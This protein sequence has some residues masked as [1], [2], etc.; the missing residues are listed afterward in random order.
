MTMTTY[1]INTATLPTKYGNI[2]TSS[3]TFTSIPIAT[4]STYGSTYG[5]LSLG[6]T[7][8]A[9]DLKITGD[10]NIAG[11]SLKS[12]MQE[13]SEKL[14]V[15]IPNP[16]LEKDWEELRDLANK[17]RETESRIKSQLEVW[18]ALKHGPDET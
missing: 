2:S 17:Y 7:Y 5:S 4:T 13:V 6:H 1:T 14:G 8:P 16:A 15:L 3:G 11:T 12:F 10:I 18:G 9:G